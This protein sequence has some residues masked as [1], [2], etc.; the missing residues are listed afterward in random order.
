MNAVALVT[1]GTRRVGR[2]IT[3]ELARAGFDLVVTWRRDAEGARAVAAEVQAMGR[4]CRALE[5]DLATVRSPHA[6]RGALGL[7]RLDALV[8]NAA[9]WDAT[10]W[11]EVD[12][13][14]MASAMQVNAIAPVVLAQAVQ[15]LLRASALPGGGAVVAVGDAHA[16]D[17]PVRGFAAY[18]M[19]KAALAQS[20]RQMAAE[21]APA[22][23]VNGVLPGVVEWPESID[24]TRREAI[25]ARIPLARAGEPQ[26]VARL[27][28]FLCIEASFMTGALV[29]VDG[30]RSIR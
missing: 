9:S 18:L 4:A 21:M 28:R 19:S 2:A 27:V 24:A 12:A 10:P 23:R 14:A 1:G 7:D 20:V 5:L 16:S 6:V 13:E 17:I 29:P 8:L 25:L 26:D 30:G 15:P 22:V 11:G 3:L